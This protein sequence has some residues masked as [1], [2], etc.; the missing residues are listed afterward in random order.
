MIKRAFDL[1]LSSAALIALSPVIALL[2][3]VI[4]VQ[5]R[6]APF[7]VAPRTARGGGSFRMVKF[8]SMT[9]GADR[10]GVDSTADGDRRI[11]PI[12]RVI[13]RYKL[14]E[15]MQ[16]W[17]VVRGD[18]SLVGPRPNVKRETDLYTAQ[19]RRLLD[20]RP[21]ITDFASI[22]FSDE[23]EILK[24]QPDPD[25]AYNQLIRPGKSRL[26]LFYVERRSLV[27]DIRLCWLTVVAVVSRRRALRGVE[28]CLRD[29]GGSEDL[30]VIARRQSPL[31]PAPP[32][33]ST[34]IVTS[35]DHLS[36][37]V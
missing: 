26:G 2:A 27:L 23:G 10:T 36:P 15:I 6:R 1:G 17:N 4:W 7:Y 30:I 32:P 31:L 5:D 29:L 20:A 21:G 28:R 16:L 19:E 24:N 13:R 33:G 34:T 37:V 9:V 11:T 3:F 12:G 8:R 14:D 18:M 35:R 22:T 25:I